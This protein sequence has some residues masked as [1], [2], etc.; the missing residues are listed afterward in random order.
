[1][2]QETVD[3]STTQ[4]A[5]ENL[6]DDW[7]SAVR[8]KD[9]QAIISFYTDD[10]T[11]FDAIMALQFRGKPAYRDHWQKCM[12]W[13]PSGEKEMVFEMHEIE[14]EASGDTAFVHALMRCGF[15]EGE[16]IDASWMRMSA[17]LRRVSGK[18]KIAHEHFS[19]PIEMPSGKAMFYLQPNQSEETVR[20]IPAGMSTVTAHIVCRDAK[21]AMSFYKKAF[22]AVE[23]PQGCLEIDGVFLHGELMIGDS[24]VMIAQEDERC[25]S[26]SPQTLQGTSVSL[27]LYVPDADQAFKRAVEAGAKEIMPV[28]EMFWGD[29][30]GVV[31]DPQGHRWALATHVRD[32]AHDEI[33]RAAEEFS[34]QWKS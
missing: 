10:V 19:A 30:Y 33:M 14:I 8:R 1:M 24:V 3:N 32:L 22:N 18:W 28:T 21:Q 23:M 15:K 6:Y 29:R 7:L 13:C 16:Q 25:G 4:L 26:A 11:A 5:I 20:P 34:L 27:H 9:V 31:E 17:G 12:E 2:Q